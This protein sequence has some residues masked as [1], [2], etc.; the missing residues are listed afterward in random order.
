[1]DAKDSVSYIKGVGA[2][3]SE[4]LNKCGIYSIMDLLLYFPRDYEII[5]HASSVDG[6]FAANKIIIDC[7]FIKA[8]SDIRTKTGKI[9]TTLLFK[10]NS[11]TF[12]CRWFNQPYMKNRFVA[13]NRYKVTGRLENYNGEKIILNPSISNI[14]LQDIKKERKIVPIY[15]LKGALTNNL[16]LKLIISVL[17]NIQIEDDFPEYLIKKYNLCSLDFAIRNIH[18][19]ESVEVMKVSRKRLKFQELFTY[20]LKVLMLRDYINKSHTGISFDISKELKLLKSKIPFKL[21]DAQSKVIKEVLIDEKS[22]RPMN[23]LLQGDVGSGKTIAALIA[24]F[25]VVKNGYQAVMMAPTEILAVQ[26]YNEAKKLL[27][28]FNINV[29]LLV[30]SM[31][32][33]NKETIKSGLKEG[34]INIIIGTHALFEDNVNFYNLG[35]VV[36]DEQ[37]RFGVMQRCKLFSKGKNVD[38]LVMTATP[39]PRT[40]SLCLYGDL[41]VSIIDELPPGRTRIKTKFIDKSFKDKAYKFAL[42]EINRGRQVYVVCPLVEQNDELDV[43]SVTGLY[44]DLKTKYFKNIPAAVL[45]GKMPSKEKESI[46]EAFKRGEIKVLISTTVIEVGINVP[47]ATLIIIENAE[48]FGL[49]QLHQLRGRV[50]RGN[51]QS[52]CVLIADVK[53]DIIRRRM[54]VICSSTDGFFIAEEDLKL[55]GPGEIFGY[56]QHGEDGLIIAD[57]IEDLE[58]FKE[59][60]VEAKVLLLNNTEENNKIRNEI[61]K[62]IEKTS[63]FICFN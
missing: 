12:K 50:G 1:M 59:A 22:S 48:R 18:I 34:S 10:D 56:R 36:T 52:Y 23:R 55:R 4:M 47:N 45:Y 11:S 16:L 63:R 42:D 15:P 31:S 24:M 43:S 14:G 51:F 20:S 2:K 30:G 53:N 9:I 8:V 58:L 37:H 7:E 46:M 28:N 25:N 17:T 27:E 19:P 6:N 29:E 39:I 35:I 40:L 26:H 13:G 44:H 60:N 62:K 3:T 54:D 38:V 61:M 21:T 57:V 49:A 41:D 33:K 32:N 5:Q